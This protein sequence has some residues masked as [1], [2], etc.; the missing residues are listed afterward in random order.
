M[1]QRKGFNWISGIFIIAYHLLLA[2]CLPLYLYFSFPVT[3]GMIVATIAI[4][5]ISGLSITV[6][7]HR[8]FSHKSFKTNRIIEAIL[9]FF[10]TLATQ[11]SAL[12]W[13]FEH[14]LHHAYVDTNRDPYSIKKGFW[15]AHI[16]WL[17]Q[18]DTPID[19]KTVSDLAKSPLILFQHRYY[20]LLMLA[21]NAIFIVAFGFIFHSF[22]ASFLFIGLIRLFLLHHSTWFI[23]SLAHVWGSR[24]YS[25]EH[26][27]VDNYIISLVTFGEGYHNYHHTFAA[28][29]RN[30]IKWYHFDPSKWIIWLLGKFQLATNLRRTNDYFI[31]KKQVAMESLMLR[32]QIKKH[33]AAKKDT[34]L[35]LV[36]ELSSNLSKSIDRLNQSMQALAKAAKSSK[37]NALE[38]FQANKERVKADWKAWIALSK[39]VM[40]LKCA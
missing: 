11:G 24:S 20:P 6:G 19:P 3:A 7:Y 13:S 39:Q 28:D 4:Y 37:N 10:G 25:T 16:L 30:G 26:S 23:N 9:L 21:V 14:R 31:K 8:Y 36:E 2:V 32:Q 38:E 5:M 17:F 40:R 33:A 27:A 1:K 18:K 35:P 22:F 34:W 29:Y 12:R 15:Y